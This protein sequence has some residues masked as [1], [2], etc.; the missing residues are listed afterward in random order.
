MD[1]K[2]IVE[3]LVFASGKS[4]SSHE[5]SAALKEIPEGPQAAPKEI[6]KL[7]EECRRDW[8]E[9]EGGIQT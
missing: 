1:L 8:E 3:A 4:I 2:N 7:L 6:E 5:I 9:R